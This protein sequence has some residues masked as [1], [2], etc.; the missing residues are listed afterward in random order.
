MLSFVIWLIFLDFM[1][2]KKTV[3]KWRRCNL[4]IMS[5]IFLWMK[6]TNP[7][8]NWWLNYWRRGAST[9]LKN[10]LL[11]CLCFLCVLLLCRLWWKEFG[12]LVYEMDHN[13]SNSMKLFMNFVDQV[14]VRRLA[15][16]FWGSKE[17]RWWGVYLMQVEEVKAR[18][19][20]MKEKLSC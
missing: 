2:D 10:L 6:A 7:N 3:T 18:F 1:D 12:E 4:E 8:L 14:S 19:L 9:T 20:V 15:G 17:M 5:S 13:L 16:G 11:M